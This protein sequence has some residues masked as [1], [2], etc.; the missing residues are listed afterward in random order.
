[1]YSP[2][3][4]FKVCFTTLLL[5]IGFY[6]CIIHLCRCSWSKKGKVALWLVMQIL[7]SQPSKYF[8]TDW[9]VKEWWKKRRKSY[10]CKEK[11]HFELPKIF[12]LVLPCLIR[13]KRKRKTLLSVPYS[14]ICPHKF[15]ILTCWSENTHNKEDILNFDKL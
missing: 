3:F 13:K 2:G 7:V 11:N 5:L 1:M 15:S 8:R 10:I 12:F 14:F 6:P 4:M 9:N